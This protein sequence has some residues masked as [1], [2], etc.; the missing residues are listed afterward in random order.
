MITAD[1]LFYMSDDRIFNLYRKLERDL[2]RTRSKARKKGHLQEA[3]RNLAQNIETDLCYV[4]REIEHRNT[5]KK[6]HILYLKERENH[7]N[8]TP[9]RVKFS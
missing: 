8:L 7:L 6:A 5:R 3:T 9:S 1:S 2:T 4:F